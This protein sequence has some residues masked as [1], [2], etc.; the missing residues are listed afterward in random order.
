MNKKLSIVVVFFAVLF[1]L[2]IMTNAYAWTPLVSAADFT[3]MTVDVTTAAV[4]II[5]VCVVVLGVF[6][7]VRAMSH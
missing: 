4:G 7:I 2:G 5:G 6:L 3:G 1:I